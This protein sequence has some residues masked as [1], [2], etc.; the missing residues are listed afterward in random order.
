M[1]LGELGLRGLKD[2]GGTI[3][4]D[5]IPIPDTKG[6]TISLVHQVQEGKIVTYF[7]TNI[8][9]S[10]W[11]QRENG[12]LRRKVIKF[13]NPNPAKTMIG[14]GTDEKTQHVAFRLCKPES[15]SLNSLSTP[16]FR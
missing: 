10:I 14:T 1:F 11:N 12:L 2:I 13:I 15:N 9:E 3:V 6:Y 8:S 4:T 7:Q 16:S 5:E